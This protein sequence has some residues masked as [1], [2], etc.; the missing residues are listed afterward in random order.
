MFLANPWISTLEDQF[1]RDDY[2]DMDKLALAV[3]FLGGKAESFVHQREEIKYFETW[4]E[5]KSSLIRMFGERDDPERIRLQTERDISTHN[6]LVSLKIRNADAIQE[7]WMPISSVSESQVESASVPAK[8]LD[9]HHSGEPSESEPVP[10]S[11]TYSSLD[12]DST[13]DTVSKHEI[14][15][16]ENK[17]VDEWK[18][19]K[20]EQIYVLDVDLVEELVQKSEDA[21]AELV[22]HHLFDLLLQRVVCIRKQLKCHKSWKFK[23]KMEDLWRFLPQNG[24]YTSMRGKHQTSNSLCVIDHVGSLEK[25]STCGRWRSQQQSWFV[26]KLRSWLRSL[27]NNIK[28]FWRDV[29]E[30]KL[31]YNGKVM[32]EFMGIESDLI[33]LEFFCF[34]GEKFSTLQHKVWYVLM[35]KNIDQSFESVMM[36]H[37]RSKVPYW[38]LARL[39]LL[40]MLSLVAQVDFVLWFITYQHK[41]VSGYIVE[42]QN[43]KGS[44]LKNMWRASLVFS[45]LR[46]V[47]ASMEFPGSVSDSENAR[48]LHEVEEKSLQLNEKLEEKL[49][50]SVLWKRLLCKDWMF[51]FKNRLATRTT[52]SAFGVLILVM[53]NGSIDEAENTL[54]VHKKC[55]SVLR[56]DVTEA[57]YMRLE[58][59]WRQNSLI[60]KSFAIRSSLLQ[61]RTQNVLWFLLVTEEVIVAFEFEMHHTKSWQQ[62][63]NIQRSLGVTT[64]MPFDPGGLLECTTVSKELEP[65]IVERFTSFMLQL[66]TWKLL[67]NLVV[68]VFQKGRICYRKIGGANSDT[69][70]RHIIKMVQLELI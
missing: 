44:V 35:V 62:F 14:Q 46:S 49:C 38:R 58:K 43:E 31:S 55:L 17:R 34:M 40:E 9:E 8:L 45:L 70:A 5:L 63:Y 24:H 48:Y 27:R 54:L 30:I 57:A 60:Q 50:L 13:V 26:Y 2:S 65:L 69:S 7:I 61:N 29:V 15:S 52:I 11:L 10:V 56:R 16:F 66:W 36:N 22:A 28:A 12:M 68:K 42:L 1:A 33:T 4:D 53:E 47:S 59:Q 19:P 6:W 41:S 3:Y 32:C 21:K 39:G 23:Y 67:I 25:M 64:S 37:L 18:S 20:V 51:K